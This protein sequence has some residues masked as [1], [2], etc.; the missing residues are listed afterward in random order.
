M[1]TN[2]APRARLVLAMLA[3]AVALTL[4][5]CGGDESSN[6]DSG[7]MLRDNGTQMRDGGQTG[8]GMMGNR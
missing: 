2:L 3:V 1:S 5:A 4:A 7:T 6:P 8:T